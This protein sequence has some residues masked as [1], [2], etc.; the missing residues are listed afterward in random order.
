M[1]GERYEKLVGS[2]YE[3]VV[4]PDTMN[5]CMR[6]IAELFEARDSVLMIMNTQN[7]MIEQEFYWTAPEDYGAYEEHYYRLDP[8][9]PGLEAQPIGEIWS[10]HEHF[11]I[12]FIRQD[13]FYN[14]YFIPAG[15]RYTMGGRLVQVR[16][17]LVYYALHRAPD[18]PRFEDTDKLALAR[19]YPHLARSSRLFIEFQELRGGWTGA[20]ETLMGL[21]DRALIVTNAQGRIHFANLAAESLL[22][23]GA[24]FQ[25]R[26]KT[27]FV[28]SGGNDHSQLEGALRD[29]ASKSEGREFVV[30]RDTACPLYL[31]IIPLPSDYSDPAHQ[32][33]LLWLTPLR[34]K[35]HISPDLL[36]RLYG[37]SQKEAKLAC[38][39]A[40]GLTLT[41]YADVTHVGYGTVRSQ[42]HAVFEKVGVSRQ[43][44]DGGGYMVDSA[45]D[46]D[47]AMD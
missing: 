7:G 16:E 38:A 42:V 47:W 45:V 21:M 19:I 13:P 25:V 39:L 30:G 26:N 43:A 27:L 31:R 6:D 12:T 33:V 15:V 18:Q 8:R 29:A 35:H 36:R 40:E 11:D 17:R 23:E 14:E 1:N 24:V 46:A 9:I 3:S 20:T 32:K 37:L 41:E 2:L 5:T 34:P 4:T 10:C 44:G 22:R 28:S